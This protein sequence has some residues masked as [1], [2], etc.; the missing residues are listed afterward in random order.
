MVYIFAVQIG[1]YTPAFCTL[2]RWLSCFT[3]EILPV[4]A[5]RLYDVKCNII[6]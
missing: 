6:V 2:S 1:L 4:V 3:G 5:W